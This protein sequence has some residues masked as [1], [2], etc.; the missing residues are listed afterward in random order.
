MEFTAG[1]A[2]QTNTPSRATKVRFDGIRAINTLRLK[3]EQPRP[4]EEVALGAVHVEDFVYQVRIAP[5]LPRS[6]ATVSDTD[7]PAALVAFGDQPELKA[8]AFPWNDFLP[9][10]N[11]RIPRYSG[12]DC[13][14]CRRRAPLRED[15]G[16]KESESERE[17]VCVR[18]R[19][20]TRARRRRRRAT[21]AKESAKTQT[22]RPQS[23]TDYSPLSLHASHVTRRD[24][25]L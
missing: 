16:A 6:S 23:L 8:M 12:Q 17:C 5:R 10:A 22:T 20:R 15:T 24:M 7:T 1:D 19:G 9:A 4:V 11:F 21:G 25:K 13:F 2:N 18:E 14:R 3:V